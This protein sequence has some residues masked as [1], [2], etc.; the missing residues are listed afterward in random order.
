MMEYD[1]IMEIHGD[2]A[3]IGLS[4]PAKTWRFIS[5]LTLNF[6]VATNRDVSLRWRKIRTNYHL[7]IEQFAMEN[8]HFLLGKPSISMGHLYHGYVSHNQRVDGGPSPQW[9]ADHR[10][11][12]RVACR[13]LSKNTGNFL[14][15]CI[16]GW[17]F[18]PLWKILV[19]GKDYPIYYGK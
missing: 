10:L 19:K 4:H 18:Q 6:F 8:H 9:T 17:W 11:F 2:K 13:N 3:D 14:H 7:A 12:A 16:T 1:G 5:I 15:H